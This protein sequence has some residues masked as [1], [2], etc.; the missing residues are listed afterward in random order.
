MKRVLKQR[1]ALGKRALLKRVLLQRAL[2]KRVVTIH[3]MVMKRLIIN[4]EMAL[5]TSLGQ[6]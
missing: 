3:S 6:N 5:K 2:L 4:M 1:M